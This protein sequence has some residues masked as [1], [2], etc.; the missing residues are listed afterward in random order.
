MAINKLA[1]NDDKTKILVMR[2]GNNN[3]E[4]S[5]TIGDSVV[6]ESKEE[7]LL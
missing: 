7:K 5:F 2:H 3:E 6:N 1:A 4:L